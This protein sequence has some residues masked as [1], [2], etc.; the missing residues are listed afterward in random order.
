MTSKKVFPKQKSRLKSFNAVY[1]LV[2]IIS[3]FVIYLISLFLP[4][5]S[6][7]AAFPLKII[8]CGHQPYIT[9]NFMGDYTY[10]KPG[11][12]LYAGPDIFTQGSDLYCNKQD[13]EE[14]GYSLHSRPERCHTNADQLTECASGGDGY[15][16]IFTF[17]MIIIV[18]SLAIAYLLTPNL[19]KAK[20]KKI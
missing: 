18:I 12:G 3:F 19:L 4:F 10:T 11:D 1:S 7:Y 17:V 9:S 6:G 16:S 14:R 15:W 2:F 8:Q 13:V 20:L 5:A